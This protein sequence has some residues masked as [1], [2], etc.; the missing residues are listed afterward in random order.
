MFDKAYNKRKTSIDNDQDIIKKI[1]DNRVLH[2]VRGSYNVYTIY[3]YDFCL[4]AKLPT[5]YGFDYTEQ[6]IEILTLRETGGIADI[7]LSHHSKVNSYGFGA[8][9]GLLLYEEDIN[10]C[11]KF[12]QDN[13]ELVKELHDL[14]LKNRELLEQEEYDPS[15][16]KNIR[17]E[18]TRLCGKSTT[19]DI[20]SALLP[21]ARWI[22]RTECINAELDKINK[23]LDGNVTW[24]NYPKLLESADI[25][26]E[27]RDSIGGFPSWIEN[28]AS[29][30]LDSIA[31][32]MQS[33]INTM[34]SVPKDTI[35]NNI[36][37]IDRI[38]SRLKY[39]GKVNVTVST[40][41]CKD[42]AQS[43]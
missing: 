10:K 37:T 38:L 26:M 9:Y 21:N 43:M 1:R 32:L 4:T 12:I 14:D 27:S 11:C 18:C 7:W 34:M 23:M 33:V 5:V 24:D 30:T 16:Y 35:L 13:M 42:Y 40:K 3:E 36:E 8:R 41:A 31:N 20:K 22:Y 15:A 29:N 39:L 25:I 2:E 28:K 17:E 19:P 6:V